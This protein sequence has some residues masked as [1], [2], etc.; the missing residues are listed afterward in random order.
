MTLPENYGGT[1]I[2]KSFTINTPQGDM[3]T[4]GNATEHMYETLISTIPIDENI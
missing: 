2:P 1:V 3:W 4:H